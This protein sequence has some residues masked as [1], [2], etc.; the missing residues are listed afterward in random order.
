MEKIRENN[1]Q[2]NITC[3]TLLTYEYIYEKIDFKRSL[4]KQYKKIKQ[5]LTKW[6]LND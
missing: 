4:S 5:V 1:L 6:L 3:F 2:L